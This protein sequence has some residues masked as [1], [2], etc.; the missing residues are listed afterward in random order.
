MRGITLPL[1]AQLAGGDAFGQ[2]VEDSFYPAPEASAE[3]KKLSP[4][5]RDAYSRPAE[6]AI[7]GVKKVCFSDTQAAARVA[8]ASRCSGTHKLPSSLLIEADSAACAADCIYSFL[9]GESCSQI[10]KVSPHKFSMKAIVFQNV[11]GLLSNCVLKAQ[12]FL[13]QGI[14]SSKQ[15]VLVEFIRRS[16]DAISF[17][18]IFR[19]ALQH[20]GSVFQLVEN[21]PKPCTADA[22][23]M[24]PKGDHELSVSMLTPLTTMLQDTAA[25]EQVQAEVTA[26]LLALAVAGAAGIVCEALTQLANSD[27]LA[28]CVRSCH[29]QVSIPARELVSVLHDK[30][31]RGSPVVERAVFCMPN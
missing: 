11:N 25:T 10:T 7:A 24:L 31:G 23:P 3:V 12:V 2:Y 18:S 26:A 13:A 17:Q 16:G 19:K 1:G 28:A 8:D 22:L 4:A 21:S 30:C 20:V 6:E 15:L 5:G 14:S 29:V 9:H 27:I